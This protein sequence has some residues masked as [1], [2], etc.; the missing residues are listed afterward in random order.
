MSDSKIGV[1]LFIE[2]SKLLSWVDEK[3]TGRFEDLLDLKNYCCKDNSLVQENNSS[4][5]S[6]A[7]ELF[8]RLQTLVAEGRSLDFAQIQRSFWEDDI[9]KEDVEELVLLGLF[10]EVSSV[11]IF[12]AYSLKNKLAGIIER[13]ENVVRTYP[14]I[15]YY[16]FK[17]I[18]YLNPDL[19]K[20]CC[21][22]L[23]RKT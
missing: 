20:A 22:R 23:L 16:D 6:K 15:E 17:L 10:G 12:R 7:F 8:H 19:R 14:E 11:N 3:T 18:S 5:L 1:K 21:R 13:Y 2:V 9:D 4:Y